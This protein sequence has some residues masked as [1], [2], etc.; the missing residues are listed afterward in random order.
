MKVMEVSY[1]E[2][3]SVDVIPTC[4]P[5]EEKKEVQK[6]IGEPLTLGYVCECSNPYV[7]ITVLS[8]FTITFDTI[9]LHDWKW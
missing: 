5:P 9:F 6:P 2:G 1:E 8:S 4:R 3:P 7:T